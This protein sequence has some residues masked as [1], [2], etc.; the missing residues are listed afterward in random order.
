MQAVDILS[1]CRELV[2]L[3]RQLLFF[4]RPL[5]RRGSACGFRDSALQKHQSQRIQHPY[6][7]TAAAHSS[8][9]SEQ[10]ALPR[11]LLTRDFIAKSLYNQGTGYFSTKDVI[12]DLPGPLEFG[13]ML[14]ELHY[15]MEVKKASDCIVL[16]ACNAEAVGMSC[17]LQGGVRGGVLL[18]V[19]ATS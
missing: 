19:H 16:G 18:H 2:V 3:R 1:S 9:S 4:H 5:F 12:N 13:S 8:N 10:D 14:G 11:A 7:A 6:A 17:L 15:R